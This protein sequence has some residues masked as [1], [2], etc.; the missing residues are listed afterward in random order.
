MFFPMRG[1]PK[2]RV[3]QAAPGNYPARCFV[4]R[5]VRLFRFAQAQATNYALGTFAG[6]ACCIGWGHTMRQDEY[7]RVTEVHAKAAPLQCTADYLPA[8]IRAW[9]VLSRTTSFGLNT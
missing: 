7:H 2:G 3:K 8:F 1:R 6:A 4:H 5:S 9:A